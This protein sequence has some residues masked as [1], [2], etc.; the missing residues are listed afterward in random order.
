M[1]TPRPPFVPFDEHKAVQ[2]Y[3]RN[4]PHWRQDG[5]T[6]FVTFRLGDSVPQPV[7]EQWEYERQIWLTARG[8]RANHNDGGW[9]Q[10]VKRLPESDRRAFHKHFDRLF[11]AALDEG[12]GACYLKDLG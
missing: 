11:H 5:A 4:L 7:L 9:Q 6:Y 12:C 1:P 2:I 10:Q 3:Q 8:I